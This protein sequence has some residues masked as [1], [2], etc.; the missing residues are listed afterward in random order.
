MQINP[1]MPAGVV[2]GTSVPVIVTNGGVKSR[3]ARIAIAR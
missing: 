2:P 1:Q 3:T